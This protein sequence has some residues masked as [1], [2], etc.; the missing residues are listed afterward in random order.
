MN[1]IFRE[2]KLLNWIPYYGHQS[3]SFNAETGHTNMTLVRGRNKGGK[4]AIIRAIKW[5]LYG[6]T[7][8]VTEYQK[9]L[10]LLNR[11]AKNSAQFHFSVCLKLEQ[12]EKLI[13]ITRTM[14]AVEG[15]TKPNNGD[16]RESLTIQE[17]ANFIA[18]DVI[19]RYIKSLLPKD[20]SDFFLFDGELLQQYKQ[21][22]GSTSSAKRLQSQ[23][24]KVIKT[25]YIKSACDDL[26]MIK[27][28][29]LK[30]VGEGTDD[31][32]LAVILKKFQQLSVREDELQDDLEELHIGIA[33]EEERMLRV[34][35]DLAAHEDMREV[36]ENIA[37]AQQQFDHIQGEIKNAQEIMRI[38]ASSAWS[39]L[40]S[41]LI[42]SN[43]NLLELE[44]KELR[45]TISK[46]K[47]NDVM[48]ML[49]QMSKDRCE[50]CHGTLGAHQIEYIKK[51]LEGYV[52][53]NTGAAELKLSEIEK[54]L[55]KISS[56]D[57]FSLLRNQPN[58]YYEN[59]STLAELEIT[60]E[61]L[62]KQGSVSQEAEVLQLI[63]EKS[64]CVNEIANLSTSLNNILAE[65]DGPNASRGNGLYGNEGLKAQKRKYDTLI[66]QLQSLK[67]KQDKNQ[68][69]LEICVK[70]EATLDGTLQILV[71]EVRK[72]IEEY[73]NELYA[74][75]TVEDTKTKLAINKGFGL[76]VLDANSEKIVTSSAGNQIVALSLMYGLKKAT[77]ISGPLLIDTPFARVDIEHRKSMLQCYSE[78]TDQV[79]LLVHGGEMKEGGELEQ[80]VSQHIGARYLISKTTDTVSSL[81]RC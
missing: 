49:Y 47:N 81:E 69:L 10:D 63:E 16:F 5:V 39:S 45:Q 24:E 46:N 19:E 72:E 65:M 28:D 20:I 36:M 68:N 78:M 33:K 3:L 70:A 62:K 7:G 26:K 50:L 38:Q 9:A 74:K 37:L 44:A 4:S 58:A 57:D 12:D 1:L 80:S 51:Q 21:L 75:M 22:S 13:E 67:P 76:D 59:K 79:I 35:S 8:D 41:T 6:E 18:G 2:L 32:Q 66:G 56:S 53:E 30:K 42:E 52:P 71:D 15:I 55:F 17:N 29:L 77:G 14:K 34:N 54:L 64:E 73:A 31:K 25:P 48:N 43:R 23:I 27:R 11:D 60:L 61:N 40:A